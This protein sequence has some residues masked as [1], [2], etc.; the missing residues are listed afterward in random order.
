MY[1]L[2]STVDKYFMIPDGRIDGLEFLVKDEAVLQ[3]KY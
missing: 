2:P 3:G 1:A